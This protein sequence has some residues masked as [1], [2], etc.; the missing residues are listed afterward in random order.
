MNRMRILL[1]VLLLALP[2]SAQAF[3]NPD[4]LKDYIGLTK[5]LKANGVEPARVQWQTIEM[6]C[7][8][9]KEPHSNVAYNQCRFEKAVDQTVYANDSAAC[10]AEARA[11]YPSSL[12]K[13]E[14]T[15]IVTL[16]GMDNHLTTITAPR[17]RNSEIRDG[18]RSLFDRC[19]LDRNWVNTSDWQMGR[20]Q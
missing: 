5:L 12:K 3:S 6:M 14:P 13:P 8:G 20:S 7:I 2:L 1:Y 4:L 9:L 11:A 15:T 19:M 17:T 18:R 16:G 10:N